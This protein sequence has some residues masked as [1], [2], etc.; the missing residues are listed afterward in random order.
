MLSEEENINTN[1]CESYD[2][3]ENMS[4]LNQFSQEELN[5]LIR[6]LSLSKTDSEI[7]ASRLREK[8]CLQPNMKI[9]TYRNM[10]VELLPYFTQDKDL[11]Y[12]NNIEGLMK[13]MRLP[14][15]RPMDWR[16]F[17]DSSSKCLK[18]VLLHNSNH[19]GSI[20]IAHSTELKEE[21]N[22]IKRTLEKISYYKNYN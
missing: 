17:I 1:G 6:D 10:E 11:V 2:Y 4:R 13:I 16:L 7:F 8:K 12:C 3:D 14:E 15:Y 19:H 20:P 22:N 9:T 18:C 5:D 21:Y